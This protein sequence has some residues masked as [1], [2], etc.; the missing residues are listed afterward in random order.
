MKRGTQIGLVIGVVVVIALI[1]LLFRNISPD[2]IS[3]NS[4]IP[5]QGTTHTVEITPTG[6]APAIITIKKGDSVTWINKREQASWPASAS[7]PSHTVYPGSGITKCGTLE[8]NTIFD[9]CRE[10]QEGQS[11]TF[12][13]NQV[14]SWNYHDHLVT[15][16]DGRIIVE[17]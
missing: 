15:S 5:L 9:A 3:N 8:E 4:T 11:Y 12:Q 1:F 6:F 10:I 17:P 2:L 16:F 13:F 14:G 7:H